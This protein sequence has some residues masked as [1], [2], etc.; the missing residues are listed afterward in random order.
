MVTREEPGPGLGE[1]AA[2]HAAYLRFLRATVLERCGSL[3]VAEQRRPHVPSGWTPLELL[4]HV[5]HV[6]RR[7]IVWGFLAE[8]VSDPWGDWWRGDTATRWHVAEDRTLEDVAAD[9]RATVARTEE[10]LATT[11]LDTRARTGGRFGP[12]TG[13]EPPDLRWICFHLLQEYARHAG[14]LDLAVE[15]AGGPTGE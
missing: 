7:W 8:P 10:V 14:H 9:L 6:E 12:A 13:E 4:D 1:E 3:P 15:V 11:P 2:H 5:A